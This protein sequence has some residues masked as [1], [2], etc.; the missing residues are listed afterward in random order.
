[1]T[2]V[3]ERSRKSNVSRLLSCLSIFAEWASVNAHYLQTTQVSQFSAAMNDS[4]HIVAVQSLNQFFSCHPG[5]VSACIAPAVV[6]R[7]ESRSRS[8]MR[9]A[10]TILQDYLNEAI[11]KIE[12]T[13]KISLSVHAHLPLREHIELHGFTPLKEHIEVSTLK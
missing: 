10:M 3:P 8:S 13:S 12:S 9:S 7:A 6:V 5:F 2:N 11:A 4:K 1:M